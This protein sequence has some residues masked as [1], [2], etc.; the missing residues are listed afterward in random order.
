[1]AW[2]QGMMQA[3]GTVA[4]VAG[5]FLQLGGTLAGAASRR[6]Q[7]R[8]AEAIGNAEALQLETRANQ[9][10]AIGSLQAQR[11][12]KANAAILARQ[13]SVLAASGF[14]ATDEGATA[15]TQETVREATIEE[16]LAVAQSE[17]EARQDQWRAKMRRIQ[18][19]G[20]RSAY[21]LEANSA[22][23]SGLTSWR[24][25]FGGSTPANDTGADEDLSTP[26]A[27]QDPRVD[28][29]HRAP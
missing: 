2:A 5:P 9:T 19:S 8:E 28:R 14:S 25:R 20:E 1:M 17:D 24:E 23:I 22:L 18:G 29:Y 13:R 11:L 15:I 4:N 16:L 10:R 21:N 27:Y 3:V 26:F 12:R 7:G 6:Q